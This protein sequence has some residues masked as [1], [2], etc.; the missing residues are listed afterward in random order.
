M[1]PRVAEIPAKYLER[2]SIALLVHPGWPRPGLLPTA[3]ATFTSYC[4]AETESIFSNTELLRLVRSG[5]AERRE[6]LFVN[7][8]RRA[9]FLALDHADYVYAE[10]AH[11]QLLDRCAQLGMAV[12]V[13]VPTCVGPHGGLLALNDDIG[14]YTAHLNL[15]FGK[16]EH[17]FILPTTADSGHLTD[18]AGARAE[19]ERAATLLHPISSKVWKTIYFAGGFYDQC[20][21]Q[22]AKYLVPF[23]DQLVELSDYVLHHRPPTPLGGALNE[24]VAKR[25]P[26][27]CTGSASARDEIIELLKPFVAA[28]AAPSAEQAAPAEV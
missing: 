12:A 8:V 7:Y 22:C 11:E 2:D 24:E 13:A 26:H 18:G 27:A 5:S 14:R 16:R 19:Q 20:L 4:D 21:H 6:R 25:L 15:L 23:A 9:G 3:H 1:R 28:L 17:V 10:L